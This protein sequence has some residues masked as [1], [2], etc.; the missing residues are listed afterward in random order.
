ME[1]AITC[2]GTIKEVE[3]KITKIFIGPIV[4]E[5]WVLDTH[6]T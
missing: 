6:I 3:E 2:I 4:I 5:R 1:E